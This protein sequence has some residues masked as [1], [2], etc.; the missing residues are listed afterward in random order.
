MDSSLT[1]QQQRR[2]DAWM[3]SP[4]VFGPDRTELI[5]AFKIAHEFNAVPSK[6]LKVLRGIEGQSPE[7]VSLLEDFVANEPSLTFVGEPPL[8]RIAL[9][10]AA[11]SP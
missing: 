11:S 3:H 6:A 9:A 1:P 10:A 8:R 4:S 7:L 2:F 5:L